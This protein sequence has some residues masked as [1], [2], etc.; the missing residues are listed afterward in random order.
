MLAHL[1]WSL[2]RWNSDCADD[3]QGR[4]RKQIAGFINY[5]VKVRKII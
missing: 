1:R 3:L 2:N 4:K 5:Q